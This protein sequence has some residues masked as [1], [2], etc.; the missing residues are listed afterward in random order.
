MEAKMR[1]QMLIVFGVLTVAALTIQMGTA[2]AYSG[3]K[4]ARAADP[5]TQQSRDAFGSVDRPSTA[6][7]GHSN[8]SE[9]PGLSAPVAANNKSCDI[10][11]CYEY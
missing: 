4:A 1:K 10:F 8:R 7:S 5:V 6:G 2:A 3:R 9:R 11:Y